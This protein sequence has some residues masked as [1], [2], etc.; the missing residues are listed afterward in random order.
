MRKFKFYYV[1]EVRGRRDFGTL[2]IE[3]FAS[4][5]TN[6]LLIVLM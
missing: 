2:T 3:R 5:E 6:K 1:T 4:T